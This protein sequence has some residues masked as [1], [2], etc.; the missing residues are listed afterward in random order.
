MTNIKSSIQKK[1]FEQ[2]LSK[3]VFRFPEI[4]PIYAGVMLAFQTEC[5]CYLAKSQGVL[6][7]ILQN[8][9]SG[10]AILAEFFIN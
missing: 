9:L 4:S 1:N 6:D 7:K 2:T 3:F 5:R 10:K 8:L